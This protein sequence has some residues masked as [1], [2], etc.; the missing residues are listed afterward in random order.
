MS[1]MD[2][3]L[4][5]LEFDP[6]S[7]RLLPICGSIASSTSE[8]AGLLFAHNTSASVAAKLFEAISWFLF[9]KADPDK[10]KLV[11]ADE[12]VSPYLNY[13]IETPD[14]PQLLAYH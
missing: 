9:H 11:S 3:I 14:V 1:M 4:S 12:L 10:A 6:R 7:P 2:G 13:H 5:V 8:A